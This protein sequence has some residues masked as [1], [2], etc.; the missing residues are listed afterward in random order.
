MEKPKVV[1]GLPYCGHVPLPCAL[2]ASNTPTK[3]AVEIAEFQGHSISSLVHNFNCLFALA[4]NM[5]DRGEATHFAMCH[6]DCQPEAGWIDILWEEMF[7]RPG[8]K[9]ISAVNLIK[10]QTEN[11][12]TSTAFGKR[13]QQWGVA[14]FVRNDDKKTMPVTFGPEL[15]GPD[16]QLLINTAVMLIDLDPA[17]W[18]GFAFEQPATILKTSDGLWEAVFEPEDWRMSRYL[19]DRGHDY[20]ATWAVKVAHHGLAIWPNWE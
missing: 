18:D 14:R 10:E 11:P 16:E 12:K 4:L 13:G 1:V 6:S 3:G 15:A 17:V 2:A 9:A 20:A 5:R 8:C 7:K 19:A